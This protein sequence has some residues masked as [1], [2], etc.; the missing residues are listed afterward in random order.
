MEAIGLDATMERYNTL[1]NIKPIPYTN[2]RAMSNQ[3][4]RPLAKHGGGNGQGGNERGA[5]RGKGGAEMGGAGMGGAY[6]L[7]EIMYE[8][9]REILHESSH[10][11]PHEI[12]HESSYKT[13]HAT[14]HKTPHTT[15]T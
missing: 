14:P 6:V 8:T 13:P 2:A 1:R 15:S 10:K 7:H 3:L 4:H 12:L 11:T 5:L 9:P